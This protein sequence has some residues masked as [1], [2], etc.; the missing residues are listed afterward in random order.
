MQKK[1]D[2]FDVLAFVAYAMHPVTRTD[3]ATHA[4]S[5]IHKTYA[6]QQEA[7]LDF[8]LSHYVE[9]GVDELDQTKLAPLLRLKYNNA[10]ADA[11]ADLGGADTTRSLFYAFQKFL[12]ERTA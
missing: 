10:I 12:Y 4:K 8:V 5:A 1:S 9:E 2:L 3:R 11:M 6:S 7:F